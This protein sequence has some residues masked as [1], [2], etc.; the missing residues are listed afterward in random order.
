MGFPTDGREA[1]RY[2]A[3]MPILEALMTLS[4]A[5]AVTST[6][7]PKPKPSHVMTAPEIE[8]ASLVR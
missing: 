3:N 6:R 1:P 7:L 8:V 4:Y 2:A 5:A